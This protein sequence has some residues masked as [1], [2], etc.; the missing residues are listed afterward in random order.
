MERLTHRLFHAGCKQP[1]SNIQA[2]AG[3]KAGGKNGILSVETSVR[4]LLL[5]A[6]CSTRIH[7]HTV[8]LIA[9]N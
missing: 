1:G 8:L 2:A 6:Y 9:N 3:V 5:S 7:T 4:Y